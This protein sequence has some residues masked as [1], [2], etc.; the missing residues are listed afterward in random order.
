MGI[1]AVSH[2][3]TCV[4]VWRH[5]VAEEQ[6]DEGCLSVSQLGDHITE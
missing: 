6:L 4:V 2:G 5:V 3:I 1:L